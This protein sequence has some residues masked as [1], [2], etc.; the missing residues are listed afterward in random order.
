MDFTGM[1]N[2][3]EEVIDYCYHEWDT[4]NLRQINAAKREMIELV[5]TLKEHGIETVSELKDALSNI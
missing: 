5:N 3:I 1:V 4:D 2:T